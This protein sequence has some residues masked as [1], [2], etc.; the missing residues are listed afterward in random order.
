MDGGR[1]VVV[2]VGGGRRDGIGRLMIKKQEKG[3]RVQSGE[4]SLSLSPNPL[5]LSFPVCLFVCHS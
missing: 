3:D 1:L 2:V 5:S 4:E